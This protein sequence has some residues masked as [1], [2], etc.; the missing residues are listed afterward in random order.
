MTTQ[1]NIRLSD[2]MLAL[3]RKHSESRGFESIQDFIRD[4]IREKLFGEAELTPRESQLVKRLIRMAEGQ[5]LY[6]S[7]EELFKKLRT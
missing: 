6:A 4:T 1:I 3:M 2:K 5:K 7:E